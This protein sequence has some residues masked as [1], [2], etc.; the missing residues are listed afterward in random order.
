METATSL[1]WIK[2]FLFP[3]FISHMFGSKL[4]LSVFMSLDKDK[5]NNA[6]SLPFIKTGKRFLQTHNSVY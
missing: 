5:T 6:L 4:S 2:K 1:V 3:S